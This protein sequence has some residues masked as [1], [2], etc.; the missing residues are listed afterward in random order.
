[1]SGLLSG[2]AAIITGASRGIGRAIAEAFVD[3]GA[4]VLLA[5]RAT[6]ALDEAARSLRERCA[7]GQH[8]ATTAADVGV[9]EEIDTLVGHAIEV[10]GRV[11]ILVNNAGIYGPKGRI[12]AVDWAEWE[13]ALRVNLFGSVYAARAIV[14][15]FRAHGGGKIVQLSG[16]GATS[17]MPYLSA[18]AAS[19]AAVV[20]FVETLALEVRDA[21]IEVNAIAPGAINT[22][23]LDEIIAA[24]PERV[25]EEQYRRALRQRAEGGAPVEH[26]ASLAVWLASSASDGI[27]G[28][29]IS[30]VWDP[31]RDLASHRADLAGRDIYTLR[32][33][34]PKDRG[35]EWG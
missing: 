23:M 11:H 17:P 20:R 8:V 35:L 5:A 12:E 28:K 27:T 31:W 34:V 9:P 14:P 22:A 10:F 21:G 24:G 3:A 13:H 18:Y 32:R 6:G 30:A 16:G 15:H 4:S 2:K 7:P 25:G 33:I 29:L 19:K 26:A 1:M